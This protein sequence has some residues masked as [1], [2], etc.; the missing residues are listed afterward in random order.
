[1][2][3][4]EDLPY[5]VGFRYYADFLRELAPAQAASKD[6]IEEG[7][8]KYKNEY[9]KRQFAGFFEEQ[10]TKPWFRE[11]YDIDA[12]HVELRARLRKQ[13]R[14]GKVDRFLASLANNALTE[15]TYDMTPIDTSAIEEAEKEQN[16]EGTMDTDGD[17]CTYPSSA[18]VGSAELAYSCRR[19]SDRYNRGQRRRKAAFARADES[20]GRQWRQTLR[21]LYRCNNRGI[22][23]HRS[24]TESALHQEHLARH[25]A[26]A[27]GEGAFA[28]L[29]RP[30]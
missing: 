17:A 10:R 19:T 9:Q 15:L 11:R 25:R 16:G 4:P 28:Y 30:I 6:N 7:Y 14:E 27:A 8:N 2:T 1:M 21:C 22:R 12:H 18:H 23:P 13:G 3:R 29:L 26:R 24:S 5:L 20:S